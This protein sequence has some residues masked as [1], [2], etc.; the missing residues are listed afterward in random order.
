[1]LPAREEVRRRE[2]LLRQ[3][4]AVGAAPDDAVDGLDPRAPDRLLGGLDDLGMAV[5][6]GAHVPVLLLDRE[7]EGGARLPPHDLRCDAPHEL[8]VPLELLVVVVAG[9]Q[10]H[11]H[12]GGRPRDPLGM[13]ESFAV[14][15]RL[16]RELVAGERRDDV[17]EQL[18]RV[19]ETTLRRAGMDAHAVDREDEP[20]GGER[21]GLDLAEA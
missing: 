14:L 18:E 17:R 7:R 20:V 13:N 9:D 5:E 19:D 12:P 1:M 6:H 8:D 10:P 4:G 3:A 21:L 11:R 2:A 16:R 15:R